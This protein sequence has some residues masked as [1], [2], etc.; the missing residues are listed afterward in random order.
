MGSS[1]TVEKKEI[2]NLEKNQRKSRKK[3]ITH[4]FNRK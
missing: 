2:L 3:K 1:L 4:T